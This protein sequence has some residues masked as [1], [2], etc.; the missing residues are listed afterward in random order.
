MVWYA[1]AAQ[2]RN[3]YLRG[4]LVV[5]TVLSPVASLEAVA[6][7]SYVSWYMLFASFWLLLWRPAS[8]RGAVLGG[9]FL[10]ATALSNPAIWYF[11]PLFGLRLLATRD[12]RD[13]ILLGGYALGAAIQLPVALASSENIVE[14]VWTSDIWTAFVQR[15]VDGGALGESLGGEAWASWGWPFL[16]ALLGVLG[17]ALVVGLIRTTSSSARY[18]AALALPTALGMFVDLHLPARGRLGDGLAAGR[19]LRIRRPLRD[20]PGAAAG[21]RRPGPDRPAAAA[22]ARAAAPALAGARGGG[23]PAG[24]RRHLVRDRRPRRP[25]RTVMARRARGRRG[26]LP[27]RAR[28]RRLRTRPPRSLPPRPA[29]SSTCPASSS[30]PSTTTAAR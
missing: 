26:D 28:S 17:G 24:G 10:L 4:T 23:R 16:I 6:A 22:T 9:L 3:P 18:F 14:P 12:R 2:I 8:T 1:S 30:S 21:Q 13:G 7:G 20:R 19:Q 29:S 11:V 15:V 27:L 5:V 25:R